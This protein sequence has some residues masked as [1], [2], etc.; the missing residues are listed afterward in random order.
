[1]RDVYNDPTLMGGSA[2]NMDNS[3]IENLKDFVSESGLFELA[4]GHQSA[5]G[6]SI[7]KENLQSAISYVNKQL[8]DWNFERIW[9]LDFVMDATDVDSEFLAQCLEASLHSF[10]AITLVQN[11]IIHSSNIQ[12]IGKEKNTMKFEFED[13]EG[14]VIAEA[15]KFKLNENDP[16]FEV[17]E[18]WSSGIIKMDLIVKIGENVFNGIT[19]KQLIILDMEIK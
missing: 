4:Q 9:N 19:T 3:P 11:V 8:K 1:M 12:M 6:I 13:A 7:K 5:F 14:F 2:R 17:L 16:I 10:T 18:D 15:I